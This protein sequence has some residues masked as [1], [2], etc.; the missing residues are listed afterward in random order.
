ME[1]MTLHRVKTSTITTNPYQYRS[2]EEFGN[3]EQLAAS[4]QEHGLLSPILLSRAEEGQ[5]V[6]I[7]GE[8]RLRAI[9][10]VL[11]WEEIPAFILEDVDQADM[12]ALALVENEQRQPVNSITKLVRAISYLSRV[13]R[14]SEESVLKGI[15]NN[16]L[17]EEELGIFQR[18]GFENAGTIKN[19]ALALFK[20]IEGSPVAGWQMIRR[21]R[22]GPYFL[23]K[24][25]SVAYGAKKV[26]KKKAR[27]ILA[28]IEAE[29]T[30]DK[31]PLDDPRIPPALREWLIFEKRLEQMEFGN[32]KQV[33]EELRRL[34][35]LLEPEINRAGLSFRSPFRER[36][37]KL[38]EEPVEEPA[39]DK[40]PV[41]KGVDELEELI[42]E[43]QLLSREVR[44]FAELAADR[45]RRGQKGVLESAR[46]LT[47][48]L[49]KVEMEVMQATA[50]E[51]LN[52]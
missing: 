50:P 36:P 23:H 43:L 7:A 26:R 27:V 17:S 34:A 20:V 38:E 21:L 24:W 11:G 14:T 49:R 2:E 13:Q 30:L 10:D 19:Y 35:E 40:P 1:E 9:R 12:E 15:L 37:E 28:G 32:L 45:A 52:G 31:L 6:L 48:A 5:Y 3:L 18:L 46:R 8:R 16:A 42:Y 33:E 29:V 39:K 47:R 51:A 44:S 25:A 4:I 22:P 41:W